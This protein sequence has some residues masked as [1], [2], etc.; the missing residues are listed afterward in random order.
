MFHVER[1]KLFNLLVFHVERTKL[2]QS[3]DV[4]RETLNNDT[5]ATNAQTPSSIIK[6]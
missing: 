6:G 5:S 3:R 4:P 1:M 2:L